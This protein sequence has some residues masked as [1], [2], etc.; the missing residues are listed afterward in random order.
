MVDTTFDYTLTVDSQTI[1]FSRP[2]GAFTAPILGQSFDGYALDTAIFTYWNTQ[3]PQS[4]TLRTVA[5]EGYFSYQP[6]L[7]SILGTAYLDPPLPGVATFDGGFYLVTRSPSGDNGCPFCPTYNAQFVRGSITEIAP[8]VTEPDTWILL[9]SG[10]ALAWLVTRYRA[11][12][13]GV[14]YER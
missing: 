2:I 14:D 12:M 7:F 4:F 5:S 8:T 6:E 10:L 13:Q 3:G 11:R 1:S 9:I